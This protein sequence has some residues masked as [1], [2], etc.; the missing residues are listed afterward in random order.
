MTVSFLS[1][2]FIRLSIAPVAIALAAATAV[3][4]QEQEPATYEVVSSFAREAGSPVTV[5]QTRSGLFYG[6]TLGPD[7]LFSGGTSGTLFTMDAAGARTVVHTFFAGTISSFTSDG[8]PMG[9]LFEASDGSVYGSAH[10][11]ADPGLPRGQIFKISP[12]GLFTPRI[13]SVSTREGVIQAREGRLYGVLEGL[14]IDPTVQFFGAVFRVEFNGTVTTVHRFDGTETMNPVGELVEIGPTGLTMYGVTEGGR[15]TAPP[16]NPPVERPGA[17]FQLDPATGD[18]AIRHLFPIGIRPTGRLIWGFDG[19]LYGTTRNGGNFGLGTVFSFDGAAGTF[20]TLY[21]FSGADGENPG[22][23]V[24][25][26]RD[27]RLYGTTSKGGAFAFG[28]VFA[29]TVT[30]ELR[31]LHDFTSTDGASPQTELIEA[32]DGAFYGVAAGGP[33]GNGVIFRV[34]LGT[35]PP[36]PD[37]FVEIVSRN[38]GKCLDVFGGSTDAGAQAIQWVCHGGANQ[39]FRLEPAG[40]GAVRIIARHSGQAL[41]VFGAL[42]DDVTPIIQW[43]VHGG[44]N[45]AWTLEPAGDGYVRIVARHSGKAMDVEFASTD[46][47]ARVIQ[48]L[49]HGGA[50]QQWLLRPAP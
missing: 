22:A 23:G 1:H 34:R 19:R 24:I 36:P 33:A 29:L 15:L 47:G 11:F 46:D 25:Q 3:S 32:N 16:Q 10:I 50:N 5:F 6:T 31:T 12:G 9:N 21:H 14:V 41:D 20:T 18:V 48:Y 39:Q 7:G 42:L 37:G 26:G 13:A 4:A 17:I 35:P 28:T 27:G 40:G 2:G 30:G 8:F 38:S 49:P 43:P 45:Q 44:D